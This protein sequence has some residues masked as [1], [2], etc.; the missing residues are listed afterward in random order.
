MKWARRIYE[1]FGY[2]N[3]FRGCQAFKSTLVLDTPATL[4]G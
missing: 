2:Q 3:K 1:N 4:T